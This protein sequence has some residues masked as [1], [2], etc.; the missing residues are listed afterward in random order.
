MIISY[1]LSR[2]DKSSEHSELKLGR[3]KIDLVFS[4]LKFSSP[5][6]PLNPSELGQNALQRQNSDNLAESGQIW[7]DFFETII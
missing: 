1:A 7:P 3:V 4:S 5:A 2:G 6:R